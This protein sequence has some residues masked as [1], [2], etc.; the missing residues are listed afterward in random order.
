MFDFFRD[1]I[2]RYQGIDVDAYNRE[3]SEKKEQEKNDKFIYSQ[4]FKIVTFIIF[5]LYL[6]IAVLNI[7]YFK[8]FSGIGPFLHSSL[9]SILAIA[10]CVFLLIP[11]RIFE[12]LALAG[13]IIFA[14][15]FYV[16]III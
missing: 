14:V 3:R 6:M 5:G 2:R 15:L 4:K 13:T 1:E 7:F 10:V 12:L 9:L 16:S 8:Y 11:K